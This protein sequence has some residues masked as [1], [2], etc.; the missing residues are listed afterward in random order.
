MMQK[1]YLPTFVVHTRHPAVKLVRD[2]GFVPFLR[3]INITAGMPV[4][5]MVNVGFWALLLLWYAG[6]SPLFDS[7][8]PN[9]SYYL[10][11][12]SLHCRQCDRNDT[13]VDHHPRIREAT[14]AP[15][16]PVA[17][18]RVTGYCR[19]SEQSRPESSCCT[20]LPIGKK[21][22]TGLAHKDALGDSTAGGRRLLTVLC[23]I[24]LQLPTPT[25]AW[26]DPGV[27][28]PTDADDGGRRPAGTQHHD[29]LAPAWYEFGALL[30]GRE[31]DTN[32]DHPGSGRPHADDADRN[33]ALCHKHSVRIR[34][35]RNDRR[36]VPGLV[37]IPDVAA[38]RTS[39]P[40]SIDVSSVPVIRNQAQVN[41]VLR[42]TSGDA[43]CGPPPTLVISDF[44]V[45]FGGD[46]R[47]PTTLQQFFPVIAPN[48]DIYV[49]PKPTSS[50]KLTTLSLV[51]ALTHYYQPATAKI[52]L[53]Q[54]P[55]TGPGSTAG[56]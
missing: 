29:G 49:D 34:G 21:P 9:S 55:R 3:M 16:G 31:F 53:R 19:R 39:A 6:R 37:K 51:T 30:R 17:D 20:T 12:S 38:G 41:M 35:G 56:R 7:I 33:T 1:G 36:A 13:L 50:E 11:L 22:N 5:C 2:L 42:V 43:I 47:P 18:S 54:L 45:A 25:P 28:A 27:G 32:G 24:A 40:F 52:T 14:V 23:A 48:V 46:V 4:A 15:T 8:F 10:C 26:A 44:A